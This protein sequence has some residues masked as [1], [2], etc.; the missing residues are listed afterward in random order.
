MQIVTFSLDAA[1]DLRR[2]GAMAKQIRKTILSY[3]TDSPDL[4]KIA[5]A[6]VGCTA[7]RLRVGEF[8]VIF[9]ETETARV[10]TKIGPR[11]GRYA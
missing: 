6:L 8:S 11:G 4:D 10:V 5:V 9:E 3:M 2:H 1:N 7:K